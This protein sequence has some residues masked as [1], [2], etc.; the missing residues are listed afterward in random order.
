MRFAW[1]KLFLLIIVALQATTCRP[2]CARL[3]GEETR[4]RRFFSDGR[5]PFGAEDYGSEDNIPSI[6]EPMVFD[7]VRGLGADRGE[8]EVNV[9]S[10]FP[11]N[12]SRAVGATDFDPFGPA[13]G[14]LDRGGIEWAPEIEYALFDGFAVEFELPFEGSELEAYK[15]A[16]QLTLGTALHDQFIHG[17]QT[18][19]E[20]HTDF[21]IWELTF[22]YL[23]GVEFSDRWSALGMIGVR[24]QISNHGGGDP[25]DGILNLTIF[26][27]VTHRMTCGL[28]SNFVFG[29]SDRTSL[30]LMPQVDVE[31]T[32]HLELQCGIGP[33]FSASDTEVLAGLRL[34]YSR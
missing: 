31:I 20:P 24:P 25:V 15:F 34:I 12:R 13:A 33:G 6:P 10:L 22:L 18:I 14:S 17:L 5:E 21:E 1:R 28:E 11:A 16:A 30:L 8:F 27:D 19:V 26:A 7:L 3:F 2:S 23:A 29:E 32:D 4:G 9:L